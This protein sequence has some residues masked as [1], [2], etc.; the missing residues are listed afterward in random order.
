MWNSSKL[1]EENNM[2]NFFLHAGV[3]ISPVTS[4]YKKAGSQ[5]SSPQ[6]IWLPQ[7]FIN[8]ERPWVIHWPFLLNIELS[9]KTRQQ[10]LSHIKRQQRCTSCCGKFSRSNLC[11]QFLKLLLNVSHRVTA[12]VS[13]FSNLWMP[14]LMFP[15]QQ[16]ISD[17]KHV[18]KNAVKMLKVFFIV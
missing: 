1:Q 10:Y 3:H 9:I 8:E 15:H 11:K 7:E 17:T 12:V 14:P 13:A 4:L 6:F 2:P 16:C 5:S 18:W